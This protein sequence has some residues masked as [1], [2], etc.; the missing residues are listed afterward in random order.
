MEK[1]DY[2]QARLR[3]VDWLKSQLIGPASSLNNGD[4]S[5]IS[6][7]SRYPVGV[8][9]PVDSSGEGVDPACEDNDDVTLSKS[10]EEDTEETF[11]KR[12]YVPP[13]SVGFSF[14]VADDDWRLQ[15]D[16]SASRYRLADDLQLEADGQIR[17]DGKYASIED[18]VFNRELLGGDGHTV[19]VDHEG[20]Y[21]VFFANDAGVVKPLGFL[22]VLAYNHDNGKILTI[23]LV[24]KQNIDDADARDYY[25]QR[26]FKSLF[27]V[28]LDCY[29]E[30][31]VI[32]EYPDISYQDLSLEYQEL[33]LQY[34]HKKV[35][36]IGHGAAV[37]WDIFDNCDAYIKDSS[38]DSN[39][40]HIYTDFMPTYEVP[41]VTADIAINADFDV[42]LLNNLINIQ[43]N[44]QQICSALDEFV[45]GYQE[46]ISNQR[47][48]VNKFDNVRRQVGTGIIERMEVAY[49]RMRQGVDLLKNDRIVAEAFG[50]AN[51]AMR[52]QMIQ[53]GYD[54]PKWRPFQ[55]AFVLLSLASCV[56][57]TDDYRQELDLIWFPTGGGKTEAY[58]AV[59]A[60]VIL[61]RRLSFSPAS[62]GGTVSMMRYTLRLLTTQQFMR[63]CRLICALELLRLEQP[64][65]GEERISIGLWVGSNSSPNTLRQAQDI[66]NKIRNGKHEEM[67]QFV[68]TSCPWCQTPFDN[69]TKNIKIGFKSFDFHCSSTQCAF[70]A[71]NI[72][73]PC[74][75]V[76][77]VLYAKPPTLLVG[78]LDK[79]AML[80]WRA[81]T[82]SFFGRGSNR[83]PELIIQDELHLISSALGSIAG[84]Y[85]AAIS[86][87]IE[88]KLVHPK[89]IASTATIKEANTQ[90][91]KLFAQSPA[92]FPPVGI[93]S[94]DSYFAKT[95]ALDEQPGRLYLGYLAPMLSRQRN[96]AP[97]AAALLIAPALLFA[98]DADAEVL[99]DA[100][101][102]ML[103]YHGSL[104]GVGNSHNSF[105]ILVKEHYERLMM[106]YQQ[107]TG[108]DDKQLE[109]DK[110]WQLMKKRLPSRLNIAQLT[111]NSTAQQ[112]ETTFSKLK[113]AYTNPESIDVALAT[114]MVSVGLDVSRMSLMVVNGQPITTAE[115]IQAS[116]RVGRSKVPGIVIA[117]YYRD[118]SRSLSH[119]E[120]FHAYHQSFYRYVEPTSVTP[121]TY[122]ARK[123]ALHAGLVIVL[124][125]SL[126][127]MSG[128][129]D[130]RNFDKNNIQIQS[131]IQA[132]TERCSDADPER[133]QEIESHVKQIVDE[134]HQIVDTD[135]DNSVCY[136]VLDDR[137]K[138]SLLYRHGQSE[139]GVWATLQSMR[140]VE[141]T[142]L[143]KL[144]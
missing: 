8:L 23:S 95:V 2:T 71:Q 60:F 41:M 133:H 123:R 67:S 11:V 7:L 30:Q 46:W 130:A 65:L 114:N 119:Y 19:T 121:Y 120:N 77:E 84:I 111:S 56:D 107:Q 140:N 89:Y 96:L 72:A 47:A 12:R 45:D 35:Y 5:G 29:I 126:P 73:L 97:L 25:W 129:N 138:Q 116:S 21:P 26:A 104:K 91:N 82:Q 85:E 42:L 79:F 76:D 94:E 144:L 90:V 44:R 31:G 112:N 32:G 83:P 75:V 68:L 20:E 61:W 1:Q 101:W 40:P 14:F 53:S 59:A 135:V 10:S 66:V 128:D 13:S 105:N 36:A 74:Q 115:Y 93:S 55:L 51:Q 125:H 24:N 92:I 127:S 43:D 22:N 100:W 137:S 16:A 52:E 86:T 39:S 54:V 9:Y 81:E 17:K 143:M 139:R 6:P 4:L 106:E 110:V 102:S 99:L 87:V 122:Q 142:G 50:L 132:F 103:V 118:Q 117:N 58:L 109:Q 27:E 28:T 80:A 88:Q 134:W 98:D 62:A 63:A 49:E 64:K 15:I 124:R 70:G 141:N 3:V 48:D 69:V 37:D 57:E 113:F 33:H 108:L 38:S 78:T 136:S 18:W 34:Q 131:A